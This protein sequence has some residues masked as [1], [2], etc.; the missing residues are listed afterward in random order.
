MTNLQLRLKSSMVGHLTKGK[1]DRFSKTISFFLR[2]SDG[3]C[4][5]VE[6]TGKRVNLGDGE[7]LQIPC[8]LHF[9]GEVKYVNKLKFLSPFVIMNARKFELASVFWPVDR[10][11]RSN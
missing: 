9:T 10:L 11:N 7:R 5:H 1:T 4:C 3:N 2:A 8:T 6:V